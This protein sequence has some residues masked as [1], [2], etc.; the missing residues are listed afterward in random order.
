LCIVEENGI[1][2]VAQR[3]KTEQVKNV[4]ALL[5]KKGESNE[6]FK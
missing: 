6:T 5:N 4:L 3:N 2:V 1:L